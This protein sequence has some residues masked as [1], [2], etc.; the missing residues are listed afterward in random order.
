MAAHIL[1]CFYEISFGRHISNCT[2]E[3]GDH[4]KLPI[5]VKVSHIA[6]REANVRVLFSGNFKHVAVQIYAL[7]IVVLA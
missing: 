6:L 5:E 3:T 7:D 1:D 2:K 4:I